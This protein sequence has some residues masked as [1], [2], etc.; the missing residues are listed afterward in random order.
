MKYLILIQ[1]ALCCSLSSY[2]QFCYVADPTA[3][4]L[5]SGTNNFVPGNPPKYIR[6]IIHFIQEDDGTGNFNAVDDGMSPANDF[7]GYD[8]AAYIIDYANNL[9]ENNQEMRLQPFGDVPV[10]DP[11]FRYRL[12]GVFFWKNSTLYSDYNALTNLQNSY[13][14]STNSAINIFITSPQGSTGGYARWIGDNTVLL[15]KP[16]SNYIQ[17]VENSNN[18]YNRASATIINHEVG[19]CL[20]LYHTIM[21]NGGTCQAT[22][23]DFC[24]DTPTIQQ[25]LNLNEPNP[26]CWNDTHCSNN[27]M[28]YNADQQ[29]ITPDQLEH[30]HSALNNEKLNFIKCNYQTANLNISDFDNNSG[31]YIAEN[32]TVSG[33]SAIIVNGKTNYLECDEVTFDTGFEVEAGGKLIVHI[34]SSC[35]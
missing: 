29:S 26:C 14:Q 30:V 28:D 11:G 4:N 9:L 6:V 2:S 1:I 31:A 23:D 8:F 25:M 16:Y 17:S 32:I 33:S 3:V 21:T 24:N 27:L 20:N 35:N 5:K 13:G 12:S 7:S 19:H 22:W 10:Y 34:N 15:F 18:W